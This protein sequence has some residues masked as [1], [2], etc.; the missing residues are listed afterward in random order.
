M[1]RST[2]KDIDKLEHLLGRPRL[3]WGGWVLDI[4]QN[5]NQIFGFI[6]QGVRL[7]I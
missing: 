4:Q 6:Q 2:I 5:I 3:W 1:V 7:R